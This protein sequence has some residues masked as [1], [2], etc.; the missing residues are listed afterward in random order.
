MI[1]ALISF[2]GFILVI[3]W[4]ILGTQF[5]KFRKGENTM[6]ILKFV[7]YCVLTFVV[8]GFVLSII[9]SV[10]PEFL[11]RPYKHQL[12]NSP[13]VLFGI[14]FVIVALYIVFQCRRYIKTSKKSIIPTSIEDVDLGI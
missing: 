8:F 14:V 10:L 2:I 5:K 6:P 13:G 1:G 12:E 9:F 4:W 11:P 3:Y 7:V